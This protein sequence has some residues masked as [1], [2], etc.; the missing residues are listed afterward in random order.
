DGI[1]AG[2][3]GRFGRQWSYVLTANF[4]RARF[5]Q[6]F[7]YRV[8]RGQ[9]EVR[10]V[11]AGNR[12]PG[13]PSAHGYAELAWRTP[14]QR[15]STAVEARVSDRIPTDDRNTDAAPGHA[16]FSLRAQWRPHGAGG[17]Y[18]FARV[19][20]LLDRDYIGSVIVNDGNGRFFEPGPGR[21]FT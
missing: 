18:G 20:N 4:I 8:T 15:F 21:S 2:L 17:W 13:I 16:R 19:D 10:T 7:S 11:D 5:E 14:S 1:E 9:T 12:I 3:D 6:D